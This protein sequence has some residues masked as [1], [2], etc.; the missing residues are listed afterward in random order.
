MKTNIGHT[1]AAAGVAGLIKAALTLKHGVLPPSLHFEKPNPD[2]P[3]EE[4]GLKVATGPV[5]IPGPA[6][7]GVNSFGFGGANA[8]V[9]LGSP[10]V[11]ESVGLASLPALES[12]GSATGARTGGGPTDVVRP[13][14]GPAA[15]EEDGSHSV[16]EQQGFVWSAPVRT[17]RFV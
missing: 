10:P 16:A 15:V 2:I 14:N 3:F 17:T 11:T 5:S 13:E 6:Y 7:A 12:A 9:V 8:H 4:L 1:E